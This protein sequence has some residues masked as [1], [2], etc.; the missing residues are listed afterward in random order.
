[1]LTLLELRLVFGACADDG[2]IAGV[3][4]AA[5][6]AM[7]CGAGL[8][9]WEA[10]GLDLPDYASPTN[11]FQVRRGGQPV[12]IAHL[13]PGG[14]AALEA[15]CAERGDRPGALLWPIR[16]DH[17]LCPGRL[18]VQAVH[19]IV[20]RRG[21]EA[22]LGSLSPR[23]IYRTHRGDL[24]D[25]GVDRRTIELLARGASHGARL[26][27]ALS[28]EA[29]LRHAIGR[30][31]VPCRPWVGEATQ[32]RREITRGAPSLLGRRGPPGGED[33]QGEA[34]AGGSMGLTA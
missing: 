32:D 23:D 21:H 14:R 34:R 8:R 2:T 10:V 17:T 30:L 18:A 26:T 22:G 29:A 9:S 5:L 27:D 12:R 16:R 4:D 31:R 1:L 28:D 15:W 20:Q 7:L 11:A 19:A 24:E 3:R 6:L 33:S 25:A 13:A